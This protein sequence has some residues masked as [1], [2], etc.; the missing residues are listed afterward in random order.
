MRSLFSDCTGPTWYAFPCS[1]AGLPDEVHGV[2]SSRRGDHRVRAAFTPQANAALRPLQ[3]A[4]AS[5]RS[6]C[7]AHHLAI[8]NISILRLS[9]HLP[10]EYW[11][12]ACNDTTRHELLIKLKAALRYILIHEAPEVPL[13]SFANTFFRF[14]AGNEQDA[15]CKEHECL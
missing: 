4:T 13:G 12:L 15:P 3:A 9:L 14:W 8:R 10:C 1:R 6:Y 11:G 2:P 7:S 5:V